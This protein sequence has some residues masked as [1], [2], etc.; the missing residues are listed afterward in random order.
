MTPY[1][2]RVLGLAI[3]TAMTATPALVQSQTTGSAD[4]LQLAQA[5]AEAGSLQGRVRDATEGLPLQGAIVRVTGTNFEARTGRDGTFRLPSLPAGTH[6]VRISYVGYDTQTTTV[7]VQPGQRDRIDV[8]MPATVHLEGMVVVGYRGA[9]SRAL[10]Q[11]R[12]SDNIINVVSADTLGDFPDV[13]IAESVARIAGVAVTRHRG[14]ADAAVIR[15]GNPAWTRVSVDGMEMPSA[16][17]GRSVSLGQM[18]SEVINAVEVTKA[19]TPD[20]D[21]DAIGGT[22]NIVTRGALSSPSIFNAKVS[23]GRSEL[24][25]R[26]NHDV[27][28]GAAYVFGDINEHGVMVSYSQSSVDRMMNNVENSWTEVDG[29]WL[30]DSNIIKDYDIERTRSALELRYD[31]MS[32]SEDTHLY[33]GYTRSDYEAD[34]DRTDIRFVMRGGFADGSTF[35]QGTWNNTRVRYGWTDRHDR[36]T[37][38]LLRFGGSH[39]FGLVLVDFGGSYGEAE[40]VRKPGR[41]SW[42]FRGELPR[43]MNYDY[44]DPNFP[45]LTWADTGETPRI[46]TNIDPDDLP[47]RHGSN[48]LRER[49]QEETSIQLQTNA[50]VPFDLANYQAEVKFGAKYVSRDRSNDENRLIVVDNGPAARDIMDFDT[51][52]NNYGRFPYGYR[53]DRSAAQAR[54]PTVTVEESIQRQYES[55]FDINETVYSGYAMSTVDMGALRLVGGVRLE[56]TETSSEGFRS[57]DNWA[58]IPDQTRATDSYTNYFPSLH[59]RYDLGENLVA[60]A[61]FSTGISRPSFSNLRPTVVVNEI[62]Q[63]ISTSNAELE[64]A[65]SQSFDLMLEY[66]MGPIGVISGG[67]F[68]KRIEDVHFGFSRFAE[69]G[70][71]FNGF[72]VPDAGWQVSTTVNSERS[73]TINGVELSWDQALTFLPAPLDGLGVFANY[74]YTD[75]KGRLPGTGESVP[76]G[77]QPQDTVNLAVYYEA[78]GFSTRLAYN[79]QS[80]RV[81]NFGDGRPESFLLWDD[82]SILDLTARYRINDNFQVFAEA[83]NLTDSRQARFIGVT[84]RV[85]ELE[86][87]GRQYMVG[88]RVNF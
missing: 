64:P 22:I 61:A 88:L 81:R 15:G 84:T 78:A 56:H 45:M 38:D 76:L 63:S 48:T 87:F 43:A 55:D 29:V 6:E 21:A 16:G 83:S 59:A 25:G 69:A 14:D 57:V 35:E 52:S 26:N 32:A 80:S 11:Q 75:S 47:F 62:N 41:Q 79:Y 8:D 24:G 5:P 19:P 67:V 10:S 27:A 46:G 28:V 33:M 20:M 17:G 44:S 49:F 36:N 42:E 30:S 54:V 37:Q 2:K 74:T 3:I 1:R 82:R 73:A 86:E 31:F 60:R 68:M 66:Y 34:E 18:T 72:I 39:D 40:N 9:Q 12:A 7:S 70:E 4:G 85:D 13:S 77:E 65:V 71:D 50:T 53:F 51:P 23:G 58:T